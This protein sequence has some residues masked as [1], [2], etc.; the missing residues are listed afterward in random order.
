MYLALKLKSF[1]SILTATLALPSPLPSTQ[2]SNIFNYTFLSLLNSDSTMSSIPA[3]PCA[4][5]PFL[6]QLVSKY[7]ILYLAARPQCSQHPC[8]Q[9]LYSTRP[10]FTTPQL[11]LP[12]TPDTMAQH[13]YGPKSLPS[14]WPQIFSSGSSIYRNKA[15]AAWYLPIL[16][17]PAL[18]DHSPPESPE[19][20]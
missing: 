1:L 19:M 13:P 8:S 14:S 20:K 18:L 4:W 15:L 16:H 2:S 12:Q 11:L 7:W 3:L 6:T 10:R 5:D 9:N 17:F